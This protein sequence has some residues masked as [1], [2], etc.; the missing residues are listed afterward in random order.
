MSRN[1]RYTSDPVRPLQKTVEG[2]GHE[3]ASSL[4]HERLP[5]P[6]LVFL[7][8]GA[9][10]SV[11][12][13]WPANIMACSDFDILSLIIFYNEDFNIMPGNTLDIRR[14]KLKTWL[15]EV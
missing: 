11:P 2:N 8:N 12:N 6:I 10:R 7:P 4:W 14:A 5:Q 13:Q 15:L 9:I 1:C 3:L